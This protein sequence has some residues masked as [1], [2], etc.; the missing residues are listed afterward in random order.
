M[1]AQTAE[2]GL[3][4]LTHLPAPD[5]GTPRRRKAAQPAGVAMGGA[6]ILERGGAGGVPTPRRKDRKLPKR[7]RASREGNNSW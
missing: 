7:E 3:P 5:L 1:E 4:L 6:Y 2:L